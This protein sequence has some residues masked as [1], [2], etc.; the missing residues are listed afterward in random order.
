VVDAWRPLVAAGS[1]TLVLGCTHYPL[2]RPLIEDVVGTAVAVI[3]SGPAVARQAARLAAA[4]G[5]GHG[6][7]ATRLCSTDAA[8]ARDA[9]AALWPGA[10]VEQ[11]DR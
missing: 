7:G 4:H 5:V 11:L 2:V 9:L 10:A 6:A 1:D 3:D 8:A